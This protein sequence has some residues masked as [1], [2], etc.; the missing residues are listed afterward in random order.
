MIH[1]GGGG[2]MKVQDQLSRAESALG[3]WRWGYKGRWWKG[4]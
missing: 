3:Y 1:L 2:G 4:G